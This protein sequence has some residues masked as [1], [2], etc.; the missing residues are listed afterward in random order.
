[1]VKHAGKPRWP[2]ALARGWS[3][4]LASGG[5]SSAWMA[6]TSTSSPA[7]SSRTWGAV[8][9][10]T[11]AWSKF[12]RREARADHGGVH[13]GGNSGG[14]GNAV[15][16]GLFKPGLLLADGHRPPESHERGQTDRRLAGGYAVVRAPQGAAGPQPAHPQF[17]GDRTQPAGKP[18][19]PP[20]GGFA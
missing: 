13:R 5:A 6:Q 15:S 7:R 14:G 12:S 1:L 9:C 3:M 4:D 18:Q 8:P 20:F 19:L 2:I 11:T 16:L 17:R 10:S